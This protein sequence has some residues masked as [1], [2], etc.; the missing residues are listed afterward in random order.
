MNYGV[1]VVDLPLG[2]YGAPLDYT[3]ALIASV[4]EDRGG[5]GRSG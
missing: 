5:R 4:R 3:C 1:E 2:F